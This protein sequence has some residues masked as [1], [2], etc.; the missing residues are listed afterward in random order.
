MW[1]DFEEGRGPKCPRSWEICSD[2]HSWV[3]SWD[4]LGPRERCPSS[5]FGSL[6]PR[7]SDSLLSLKEVPRPYGA[8]NQ[9]AEYKG[10]R[11]P[12]PRVP[13]LPRFL[14][15]HNSNTPPPPVGRR[16][17][18]RAQTVQGKTRETCGPRK[19]L[20]SCSV[21]PEKEKW[22]P[23]KHKA[24]LSGA[25]WEGITG[26]HCP[27]LQNA[28]YFSS[29]GS[30]PEPGGQQA[31]GRRQGAALPHVGTT[32]PGRSRALSA[33]TRAGH[34]GGGRRRA[35][36]TLPPRKVSHLSC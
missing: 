31:L 5:Q 16:G 19:D 12:L 7:V 34:T 3:N 21:A 6:L 27:H 13:P 18:W 2:S 29:S 14:R 8:L 1:N 20:R 9:E 30:G 33:S 35:V 17:C 11:R 22:G 23:K 25:Q 24:R 26:V 4:A 32:G 10:L 36:P 28:G 15:Q